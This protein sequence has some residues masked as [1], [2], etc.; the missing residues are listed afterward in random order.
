MY[1]QIWPYSRQKLS[2]FSSHSGKATIFHANVL[3][4]KP[5]NSSTPEWLFSHDHHQPVRCTKT[6]PKTCMLSSRR[7][8]LC[9][10]IR[11]PA[12]CQQR[13]YSARC[14][15]HVKDDVDNN[16]SW[17]TRS[18]R[19]IWH[20]CNAQSLQVFNLVTDAKHACK[21]F[22]VI[23]F[24]CF[25]T[26]KMIISDGG[27]HFIDRTFRNFLQELGAKHDIATPYHLQTNYQVDL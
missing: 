18:A 21:M 3:G 6:L 22:H 24:P 5:D 17:A 26:P 13:S 25:G 1:C 15:S 14:H 10:T 20:D 11:R 16:C 2:N 8:C 23:I 19:T 4:T 27:S 9:V 7:I 12:R